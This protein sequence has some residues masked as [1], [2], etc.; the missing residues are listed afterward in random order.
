[1]E[2]LAYKNRFVKE[3]VQQ[4]E[5]YSEGAC[6][7]ATPQVISGA[8]NLILLRVSLDEWTKLLSSVFTGADICYPD[9]SD[10]VRW[11][12]L[13]AVE[14]PMDLCQLIADCINDPESPARQAVIDVATSD[15]DVI[16]YNITNV[17]GMT[18]EQIESNV[19]DK[20]CD[21][22]DI[23]GAVIAI[24][25]TLDEYI[26][27]ALQI[28]EL[29]TNDEERVAS[30]IA[31][32]PVFGALP[33]DEV[34]D[35][36]QDLLEDFGENYV[37]VMT[38][39][40]RDEVSERLYCL[41]LEQPDCQLTFALLYEY[42]QTR[43]TSGLDLFATIYDLANFITGGDFINDD[44]ILSGMY[45]ILLASLK[46][47][48]EFFGMDAPKIGAITRDAPP[49]SAWEDWTECDP[50]P[51]D[52]ACQDFKI[53]EYDWTPQ[54]GTLYDPS[55]GFRGIYYAFYNETLCRIYRGAVSGIAYK[56]VVKFANPVTNVLCY[57]Q[58]S[59]GSALYTGAPATEIEFS[60]D[61]FPGAWTDLNLAYGLAI[62]VTMTGDLSGLMVLEEVCTYILE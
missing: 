40:W 19:L 3:L 1:M 27:D 9:E 58:G 13:R 35:V 37:A 60:E 36:A 41:A 16:N 61:T 8:D 28:I 26:T 52:P 57:L 62:S 54:G 47:G 51:P 50:P 5:G 14:C 7:S 24:V 59:G 46:T 23:A 32:I 4:L 22:S 21:A 53:E 45:A 29:G 49:S 44:A 56:V 15:P 55:D 2:Q 31:G 42:F 25:N 43:A 11:S 6:E 33:I 12:L 20:G 34:I 39:E 48:R 17:Q 38:P 18:T 30:V 10:S